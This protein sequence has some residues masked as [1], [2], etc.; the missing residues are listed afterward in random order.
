MQKGPH[1][2]EHTNTGLSLFGILGRREYR[3]EG[4]FGE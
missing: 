4:N 3:M 2:N 1:T